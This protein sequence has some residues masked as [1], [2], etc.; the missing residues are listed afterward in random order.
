MLSLLAEII[1]PLALLLGLG[2]WA[3]HRLA[4]DRLT[5]ARL[6]TCLLVPALLF[7]RVLAARWAPGLALTL[8]CFVLVHAACLLLLA[9]VLFRD[10]DWRGR[11]GVPLCAALFGNVGNFGLPVVALAFGPPGLDVL[12]IVLLVQNI[13]TFSLGAALLSPAPFRLASLAAAAANPVLAAAALALALRALDLPL[14]AGAQT[15]VTL[16]AQGLVPLALLSLGAELGA[17]GRLDFRPRLALAKVALLR[18]GLAPVLAA[19]LAPRFGLAPEVVSILVVASALPV[20]V[21]VYLVAAAQNHEPRLAATFVF[22][23]TL[24]ALPTLPFWLTLYR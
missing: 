16:L 18:L 7:E 19:L 11:R 13:L 22:G 4:L 5:L 21:N 3:G 17:S 14:P 23:T 15:T 20:A 8:T 6:N 9:R 2:A 12:A 24:L 10:P 1:L